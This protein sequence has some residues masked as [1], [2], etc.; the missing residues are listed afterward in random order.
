MG[1]GGNMPWLASGWHL[2]IWRRSSCYSA[3]QSLNHGLEWVWGMEL[4]PFFFFCLKEVTVLALPCSDLRRR[5]FLA[6]NAR[7]P[8]PSPGLSSGSSYQHHPRHLLYL[9]VQ[10]PETC[11][12]LPW[13]HYSL[14]YEYT[15]QELWNLM[16]TEALSN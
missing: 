3:S 7:S 5:L 15:C 2:D 10:H 8:S 14:N 1:V 16:E 12:G 13:W 6:L 4:N 9:E 11:G